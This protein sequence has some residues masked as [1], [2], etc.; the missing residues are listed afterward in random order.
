MGKDAA[1]NFMQQAR[2]KI[3]LRS[4]DQATVSYAC[5]L[6]GEFERN[7]VFGEG[8]WESL[9]QR[10]LISGWSPFAPV[11]DDAPPPDAGGAGFYF[12]ARAAS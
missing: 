6:A 8:Q 5:W 3:F 9:D 10:E 11:D 7:R 2:S 4:E 12:K 1:E